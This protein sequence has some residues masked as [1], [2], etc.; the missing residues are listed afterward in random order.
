MAVILINP[1]S[2]EAMTDSALTAARKAS[3]G[4]VFEGWTSRLGPPAIE[5]AEDGEA[6]IPP[7]LD[8]VRKASDA[9]AQAIV[10]ACFDDTGLD[11]ARDMAA[12]PVI[13][14]GEAS[15]I[16]AGL[17]PGPAAVITTV[18]AALPVI[19]GNIR[20]QGHGHRIAEVIAAEVPVLTLDHDPVGAARAFARA[21]ERLEGAPATIIL[22]CA[23]AV[24]I[25]EHLSGT[26]P[27]TFM[28]GV[29]AAARLCRAVT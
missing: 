21:T 3:P 6:A 16:M 27:Y 28:D 20:A 17:L 9:G 25:I 11:A 12:C 5:G 13:G 18:A 4:I 7:L 24:T 22:G 8:L 19:R 26:L 1:N 10:I 29:T 14:I 23:G 15:Y 2:T